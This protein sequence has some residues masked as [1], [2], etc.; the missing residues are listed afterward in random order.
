[1]LFVPTTV[2]EDCF[3][4]GLG[5]DKNYIGAPTHP[6]LRMKKMDNLGAD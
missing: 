6:V 5:N 2:N 3:D 1:M 4:K